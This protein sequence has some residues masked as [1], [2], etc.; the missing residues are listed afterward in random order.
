MSTK[1]V[2]TAVPSP[3]R[4]SWDPSEWV[5]V[6]DKTEIDAKNAAN[7][8]YFTYH[9]PDLFECSADSD[10][11]PCIDKANADPTATG[12]IDCKIEI[13]ATHGAVCENSKCVTRNACSVGVSTCSLYKTCTP[14]TDGDHS[15][16]WS[17]PG[18]PNCIRDNCDLSVVQPFLADYYPASSLT[19]TMSEQCAAMDDLKECTLRHCKGVTYNIIDDEQGEVA[20]INA[21]E[22]IIGELDKRKPCYCDTT[23]AECKPACQETCKDM[24]YNRFYNEGNYGILDLPSTL[25][26]GSDYDKYMDIGDFQECMDNEKTIN[27][28]QPEGTSGICSSTDRQN[29]K[30]L[31]NP[32]IQCYCNG[33]C[34]NPCDS[35]DCGDGAML[36]PISS[37]YQCACKSGMTGTTVEN[38]QTTCSA[39]P[40]G[41]T[42]STVDLGVTTCIDCPTDYTSISGE[43][44][45]NYPTCLTD[46]CDI[47]VLAW[48]DLEPDSSQKADFCKGLNDFKTCNDATASTCTDAGKTTM[49]SR[50]DYFGDCFCNNGNCPTTWSSNPTPTL[51]SPILPTPTTSPTCITDAN[52]NLDGINGNSPDTLCP[53]EEFETCITNSACTT[54]IK[55]TYLEM[56]ASQKASCP[57]GCLSA[58]DLFDSSDATSFMPPTE[59]CAKLEAAENCVSA[60]TCPEAVKTPYI[61]S[62]QESQ[63]TMDCARV[64]CMA[65]C[66]MFDMYCTTATKLMRCQF[67]SNPL[68]AHKLKKILNS[69]QYQLQSPLSAV[70]V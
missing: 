21:N 51:P 8:P 54:D 47:N 46:N 44:G 63:T 16:D 56:F 65:D 62:Y 52:C 6:E 11:L 43:Q 39:C 64:L 38:A 34:E 30:A 26:T 19:P 12:R 57:S 67:A 42:S 66:D 3:G 37:G 33:L 49:A 24:E 9:F 20:T 45:C 53:I 61:T 5:Q 70:P 15:C 68:R 25:P 69:K 41:K 18:F 27:Y 28:N 40:T 59:A 31:R 55:D 29:S 22:D 35:V 14:R 60:S 7:F 36:M 17:F 50:A 10:C 58:C 2:P 1:R 4:S 13:S 48:P 23:M 32:L